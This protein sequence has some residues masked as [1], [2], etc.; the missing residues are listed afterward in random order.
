VGLAAP[1]VGVNLRL[2]VFNAKGERGKGEEIVLANPRIISTNK[3]RLAD[4][5]GCLSFK[6]GREMVLGDVEV[7]LPMGCS[8]L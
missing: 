3:K 4:E 5:E 2:M 7:K 6:Y 8:L 1:Q